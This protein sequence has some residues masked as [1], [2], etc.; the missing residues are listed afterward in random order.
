M[1]TIQL[2]VESRTDMRKGPAGR[3]RRE[4]KVPGVFYGP[5]TPPFALCFNAREFRNK[6]MGLEGSQLLQLLSPAVELNEKVALLK[7]I[8]RHPVTSELLH[9]D[10]YEI[11]VNKP[12][13]VTV[14]LHFLGKA[15]GVVAGGVLQSLRRDIMVECLPRDIPEFI[16]VD[17][18]GLNI[19]DAIHIAELTLPAGVQAI[20][21]TNDPVVTVVPPLAEA[22]P[23]EAEAEGA[24]EGAAPVEGAAPAEGEKK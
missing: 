6:L 17:V 3:L 21:E 9:V 7:E 22:K 13:Q 1:E 23:V 11:D 8:Q 24:A 12:L 19:H 10:F 2:T 16:E 18:S 5:G 15:Q 14:S 4:G 20:Y